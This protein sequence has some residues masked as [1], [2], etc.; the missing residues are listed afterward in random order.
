MLLNFT[1][2]KNKQSIFSP[3]HKQGGDRDMKNKLLAVEASIIAILLL[4]T[5]IL[6]P[7]ESS[8]VTKEKLQEVKC[9]VFDPIRGIKVLRAK[10]TT[11]QIEKLREAL[12]QVRESGFGDKQ[13]DELESLMKKYKLLPQNTDLNKLFKEPF[14]EYY[15]L[16]IAELKERLMER[17]P[18]L[19]TILNKK[20]S[21]IKSAGISEDMKVRDVV[22]VMAG[23][24]QQIG[25]PVFNI[26][27][28]LWIDGLGFAFPFPPLSPIKL[29]IVGNAGGLAGPAKATMATWGLLGPQG[30][31]AMEIFFIVI[32]FVG[33]SLVIEEIWIVGG[34][35]VAIG[36]GV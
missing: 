17:Y 18:F 6:L 1:N 4:S 11:S 26:I 5:G 21:E 25:G 3:K 23:K 33:I 7:V 9:T 16:T 27:C 12:E 14:K 24:G 34:A 8:K 10:L 31:Y 32:G 22:S 15:D 28:A 19:S 29:F 30:I 2:Y 35:L 36:A 20:F 13:I